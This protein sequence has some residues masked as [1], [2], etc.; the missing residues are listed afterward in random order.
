MLYSTTGDKPRQ[1]MGIP[2]SHITRTIMVRNQIISGAVC[3]ADGGLAAGAIT[4]EQGLSHKLNR[5]LSSRQVKKQKS[6]Y[7]DSRNG[8]LVFFHAASS[9][10]R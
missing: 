2:S 1:K 10:L 3:T 8:V 7:Q 5:S 6:F 9:K 4:K